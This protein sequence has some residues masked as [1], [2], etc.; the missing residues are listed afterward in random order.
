MLLTTLA[1]T[2]SITSTLLPFIVAMAPLLHATKR[3][4]Q[5]ASISSKR[6][7]GLSR[8]TESQPVGV[9][10]SQ[11]SSQRLS[12]RKAIAASQATEAAANTTAPLTFESL[13][14][15]S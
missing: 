4:G 15:E 12:P 1:S 7:K 6:R 8:G 10:A 14:R 9:D 11:L 5:G 2:T 3:K 13:L